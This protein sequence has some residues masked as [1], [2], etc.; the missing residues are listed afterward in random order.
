LAN[1]LRIAVVAVALSACS[2][3][4]STDVGSDSASDVSIDVGS[5]TVVDA[6]NSDGLGDGIV[7]TDGAIA[8]GTSSCAPTDYCF[9]GWQC[10][11]GATC[12]STCPCVC[13]PL[14][15]ACPA[16]RPCICPAGG[17]FGNPGEVFSGPDASAAY[18]SHEVD[19]YGS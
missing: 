15:D 10:A 9:H 1:V 7:L 13:G 3:V 4:A 16:S 14:P 19:C 8:C 11:T 6:N 2:G 12:S 18:P 5:D 17:Y